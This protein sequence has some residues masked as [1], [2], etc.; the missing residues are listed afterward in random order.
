[1]T[2]GSVEWARASGGAVTGWT[3]LR[4]LRESIVFQLRDGLRRAPTEAGFSSAG[5]VE[6]ALRE[7]TLP[8][9]ELVAACHALVEGLGPPALVGHVVRTYVWGTLLGLRDGL[10]WDRELFASAA[11]LHDV[12]LARRD[13]AF[14]CFAH[15]GAEQ[16]KAF[17]EQHGVSEVSRARVADAICLHLRV[18]VPT[19]LG[20]EAHLVHAGAGLDVVGNRARE[21]PGDVRAAVL[22][23]HPRGDVVGVLVEAFRR[24]RRLHPTSRVA[25]WMSLGFSRF[26]RANPLERRAR[27]H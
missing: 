16:A 27:Q 6:R 24:E 26:I 1:M 8:E 5:E 4:Q 22:E 25:R 17:L 18:E 2:F 15:D 19:S 23:R 12:A 14:T 13:D 20:V 10:T 7:A 11:L 3:R 9:T 21:I